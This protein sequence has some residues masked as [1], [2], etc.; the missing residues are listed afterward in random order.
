MASEAPESKFPQI[1]AFVVEHPLYERLNAESV[2]VSY[3]L[4]NILRFTD[5]FDAYCPFCKREAT[6]RGLVSEE[7]KSLDNQRRLAAAITPA[8]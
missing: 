7:T 6:F 1:S 2:T 3:Y 4:A 5:S 8:D